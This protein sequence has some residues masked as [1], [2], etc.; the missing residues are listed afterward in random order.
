M[1]KVLSIV[2]ILVATFALLF[3]GYF[4]ASWTKVVSKPALSIDISDVFFHERTRRRTKLDLDLSGT[5]GEEIAYWTV[6]ATIY[7]AGLAA[8][9]VFAVGALSI[10]RQ[11]KWDGDNGVLIL[12]ARDLERIVV[13]SREAVRV[14]LRTTRPR[15]NLEAWFEDGDKDFLLSLPLYSGGYVMSQP[16][17]FSRHDVVSAVKE[18][19]EQHAKT[20]VPH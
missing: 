20:A 15:D 16:H 2:A 5:Q 9:S 1:E 19:L 4:N 10:Q 11:P 14:E 18:D 13:P 17:R 12:Q 8:E 6:M 3:G 7:N